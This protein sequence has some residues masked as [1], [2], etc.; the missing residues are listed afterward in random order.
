MEHVPPGRPGSHPHRSN[1]WKLTA[2]ISIAILLLSLRV[3]KIDTDLSSPDYTFSGTEPIL[4]IDLGTTRSKAAIYLPNSKK[5][6]MVANFLGNYVTPS[7]VYFD[8]E[9]VVIG[10][11]AKEA[12]LDP[13]KM[14]NVVKDVK[15]IIGRYWKESA[16]QEELKHANYD[17]FNVGG[18]PMVSVL[19]GVKQFRPEEISA[20]ILKYLKECAEAKLGGIVISRA[21]I[22]IPANFN[23]MQRQAT[24]KAGKLSGF[25]KIVLINEPTAAALVYEDHF[26][27]SQKRNLLVFDFGGGT[28]DVSLLSIEGN[29]RDVI[30]TAGV[31]RLG[32][33]DIDLNLAKYLFD[34]FYAISGLDVSNDLTCKGRIM[35]AA[36][37][38]KIYL[39]SMP[40]TDIFLEQLRGGSDL[41]MKL[42]RTEFEEIQRPI[43]DRMIEPVTTVLSKSGLDINDVDE[44][45]LMGGTSR[46]PRVSLDIQAHFKQVASKILNPDED[47]AK[48]AAIFAAILS[49]NHEIQLK[50][51]LSQPIGISSFNQRDELQMTFLLAENTRIPADSKTVVVN[52]Y[53]NQQ[54]VSIEIFQGFSTIPEENILLGHFTLP[55]QNR[56]PRGENEIEVVASI[57]IQGLLSVSA[58]EST[59][60]QKRSIG[61][62]RKK[63]A[64]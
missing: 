26:E 31:P 14:K 53:D 19:N 36:E 51:V 27:R 49:G 35:R 50:E 5:T 39:S 11:V 47:V 30:G 6:I 46:I 57:D 28:L 7:Y 22:T 54:S 52:R 58:T 64:Y 17:L 4:A 33:E 41:R 48:G 2:V 37:E 60:K 44:V 1:G 16:V 43:F 32:G 21:V 29:D 40:S 56:V 63:I 10:E 18:E 15:R 59:S 3:G 13:S 23:D 42:T 20:L 34:Q 62:D 45:L 25:S 8:G 61:I 12:S 55:L 24:I 9:N 38:A